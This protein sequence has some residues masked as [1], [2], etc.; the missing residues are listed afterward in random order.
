MVSPFSKINPKL[1]LLT[2]IPWVHLHVWLKVLDG[3]FKQATKIAFLTLWQENNL[4]QSLESPT[5]KIPPS[6]VQ[7]W[8]SLDFGWRF[9]VTNNS[10]SLVLVTSTHR[11][12]PVFSM[13]FQGPTPLV[14]LVFMFSWPKIWNILHMDVRHS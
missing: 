4:L 13:H 11:G 3:Y 14:L 1:Q 7:C 8:G 2:R 12:F 10:W 6:K 5:F 9:S